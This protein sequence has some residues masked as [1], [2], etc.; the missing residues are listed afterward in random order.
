MIGAGGEI[1]WHDIHRLLLDILLE[2]VFGLCLAINDLLAVICCGT[3]MAASDLASYFAASILSSDVVISWGYSCGS[4]P[5]EST[6]VLIAD[7]ILED[8]IVG[9]C[10]SVRLSWVA[11]LL[12]FCCL[13]QISRARTND[14]LMSLGSFAQARD[15]YIARARACTCISVRLGAARV[16]LLAS[17]AVW[18][19]LAVI[20]IFCTSSLL[21]RVVVL[22][23]SELML[24]HDRAHLTFIWEGPG[25][26]H[27]FTLVLLWDLWQQRWAV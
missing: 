1:I 11:I 4:I 2:Q 27:F 23:A 25:T 26:H 20:I 17:K 19:A 14:L 10:S 5:F 12:F 22:E 16:L 15:R 18:Q 24:L 21:A 3:K 13:V 6:K 9:N 8:V 7:E